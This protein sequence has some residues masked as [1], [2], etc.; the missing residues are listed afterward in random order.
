MAE[1]VD[2]IDD[3]NVVNESAEEQIAELYVATFDRAPDQ[4]GLNYWVEQYNNGMSLDDISK[5]FFDQKETEDMYHGLD[6]DAFV[7][8]VY[9]HVL[10]RKP[11]SSGAQYWK[12]ELDSGHITKDE[13]I[14][15][16]LNGAK[17]H[18]Q[19][20]KH[21]KDKTEIGLTYAKEDLND[22]EKA[23]EVIHNYKSHHNKDLCMNDIHE[24]AKKHHGEHHNNMSANMPHNNENHDM[25]HGV[26]GMPH[27]N[28]EHNG[29][30]YNNLAN[31]PHH[32]ENHDMNHGIDGMPHHNEEHHTQHHSEYLDNHQ[33]HGHHGHD[34]HHRSISHD[35]L[36]L[37]ANHNDSDD[38]AHFAM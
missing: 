35:S 31:I 36:D 32:N 22:V 6:N 30:D 34:V 33:N 19:D 18:P 26:D 1:L 37:I 3:V 4:E 38:V 11:D 8:S 17:S 23:K 7:D 15:A 21:L 14:L 25:E 10:D 29:Y 12:G 24:Y 2:N 28:E 16:I 20:H 5:S 13:F 9:D 27:H